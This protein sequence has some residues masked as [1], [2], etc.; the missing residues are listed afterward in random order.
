MKHTRFPI[1]Q[2]GPI[3][4]RAPSSSATGAALLA[5]V[6]LGAALLL[7]LMLGHQGLAPVSLAKALFAEASDYENWLLWQSRLPRALCALGAGMALGLSGAVF[8]SLS[9]NPLGSPDI[10]G[11]NAGASAGAVLWLLWLPELPLLP[12]ALLGTGVVL[13]LFFAGLGRQ[14]QFSRNLVLMGIAINAFAIAL[15]QFV[16]TLVQREQAQQMLGYLSGSLAHRT[17]GDVLLITSVLLLALPALLL[18]SRRLSLLA[19]GQELAQALGNPVRQSQTLALLFATLLALGAVLCAGPVAFVAL[20]APHLARFGNRQLALLRSALI[21]AL[22]LLG[23]DTLTL[24][25]PGNQRL[26]VG[27]L[28]ALIGGAYL[29][30]LLSREIRGQPQLAKGLKGER[31]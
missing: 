21:G 9:R 25:L 19:L 29:A 8:Q 1:W 18:L 16:L 11:V 24:L 14:W 4:L 2:W 30:L 3:T 15:V 5:V 20:V 22:L 17:W 26:P 10:L 6:L 31:S 13:L 7:S 23:A 12:G 27:V 28:T